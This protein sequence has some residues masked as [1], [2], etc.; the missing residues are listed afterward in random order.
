MENGQGA[1]VVNTIDNARVGLLSRIDY[2][3]SSFRKSI[4]DA[5]FEL[6]KQ[7]KTQLNLLVGG[8]VDGKTLSEKQKS[9]VSEVIEKDKN[10]KKKNGKFVNLPAKERGVVRKREIENIFCEMCAKDLADIIPIL[11]IPDP[12]N[13]DKEKTVDLFLMT[14]QAYDGKI[15]EKIALM[16]SDFRPDIRHYKQG[17]DRVFIKYLDKMIHAIAPDKAVLMSRD[18]YST[19]VERVIKDQVKRTSKRGS[20]TLYAVGCYGSSINKPMGELSYRYIS[21]PNSC[22]PKETRVSENQ[23]GV[24]IADFRP[25]GENYLV[26]MY[27]VKDLVSEELSFIAAPPDAN[28]TQRKIIEIMKTPEKFGWSTPGTLAYALGVSKDQ[29]VEEMKQLMQKKAVQKRGHSFPGILFLEDSRKYIF[30]LEWIQRKLRY[31]V[32]NG[33]WNEDT[34]I[35]FACL[36]GGSIE[37]DIEFF[38]NEVPKRILMCGAEILVGAGDFIE[39]MEHDLDRKGQLIAGMNNYTVQEMFTAH[40]VGSVIGKVFK[41]RFKTFVEKTNKKNLND[42]KIK[43]LVAEALLKFYYIPGNH[44]LWVTKHGFMPLKTF[45]DTLLEFLSE[46]IVGELRVH[47]LSP[48]FVTDVVKSRIIETEFFSLPSGL[49]VC[50]QHPHMSRTKTTSIR[51]Q[52]MLD[53]AKRHGCQVSIGANFHTSENVEEWDMNLGQCVSHQIGTIKHGSDFERHKMKIVDQGVGFVRI[54][55]KNDRIFMSESSFYGQPRPKAR[56]DNISIVNEFI[57]KTGVAPIKVK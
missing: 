47:D 52:E 49:K 3:S 40:L 9:Y 48:I 50:V 32:P 36:H 21:L 34:I 24:K 25:N 20:P 30:D 54:L 33:P 2:G 27:N 1:K 14:S 6:L 13:P 18:Y 39:G 11:T 15:G 53:Y 12:E 16:L 51:P 10:K 17:G 44:D 43:Y 19:P 45:H 28:E 55:S 23:I 7:E 41:E 37:T 42:E 26:R 8:L 38:V 22:R 35:T 5:E 31:I 29:V 57:Q 56:V 46:L 4:I